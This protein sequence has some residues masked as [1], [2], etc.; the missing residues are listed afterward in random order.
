MLKSW[1]TDCFSC[2]ILARAIAIVAG[3]DEPGSMNFDLQDDPMDHDGG[4][5]LLEAVQS[6]KLGL[7]F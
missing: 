2:R 4:K 3:G 7:I 6:G 1:L 5:A